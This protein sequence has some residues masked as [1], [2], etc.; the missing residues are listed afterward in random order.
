M[1]C[2]LRKILW[3]VDFPRFSQA[4]LQN[5]AVLGKA[6][7]ATVLITFAQNPAG[8][9]AHFERE[10]A[11]RLGAVQLFTLNVSYQRFL[12]TGEPVDEVT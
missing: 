6:T 9:D 3:A 12:L 5:S 10:V 8:S 7:G 1:T 2:A 4:G 11:D